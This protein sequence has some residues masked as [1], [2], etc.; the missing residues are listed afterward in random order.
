MEVPNS[1]YFLQKILLK[2]HRQRT[3]KPPFDTCLVVVRELLKN[4]DISREKTRPK[5]LRNFIW[6]W[7]DLSQ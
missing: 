5:L 1:P 4:L 6:K 2:E 7:H 3:K